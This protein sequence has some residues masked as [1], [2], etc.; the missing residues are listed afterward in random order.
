MAHTQEK[1]KKKYTIKGFVSKYPYKQESRKSKEIIYDGNV[2][3]FDRLI[4]SDCDGK[5]KAQ[6]KFVIIYK[7]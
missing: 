1:N 3:G 6:D 4:L 2:E 7:N 5:L